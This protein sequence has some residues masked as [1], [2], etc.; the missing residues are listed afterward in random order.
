LR[1]RKPNGRQ[2]RRKKGNASSQK[3]LSAKWLVGGIVLLVMVAG[4]LFY[5]QWGPEGQKSTLV[6]ASAD[7]PHPV[8]DAG[9][10]DF[11]DLI[12]RWRRV[13]G[14]YR[15][16]IRQ[17]GDDGRVTA[18]YHNPRPINVARA[19]ALLK[20]GEQHVYIEFQDVGYPGSAYALVYR[21]KDDTLAGYYFQA[22]VKKTYA[23]QFTRTD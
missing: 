6:K 20:K 17:V 22:A 9:R 13:D 19:E 2:P 10:D 14:G 1:H 8:A 16:E 18:A 5:S 3:P 15:L 21:P 23:V 7:N 4:V 11:T 12:G